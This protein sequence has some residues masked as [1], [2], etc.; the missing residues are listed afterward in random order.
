[1]TAGAACLR[2]WQ[3]QASFDP[4]PP[5]GDRSDV[6]QPARPLVCLGTLV[7]HMAFPLNLWPDLPTSPP[8]PPTTCWGCA[9]AA[10]AQQRPMQKLEAALARLRP[11]PG[12]QLVFTPRIMTIGTQE[13][14]VK[15]VPRICATQNDSPSMTTRFQT[16][17]HQLNCYIGFQED[18]EA[19][20]IRLSSRMSRRER[21][22]AC[23]RFWLGSRENL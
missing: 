11:L 21:K 4:A 2:R 9:L 12:L 3:S 8:V 17:I 20:V 13:A 18:A 7:H 5:N 14:C 16:P 15:V 19:C 22:K 10:L 6:C 1:M 23:T